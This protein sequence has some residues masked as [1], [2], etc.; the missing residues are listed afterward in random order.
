MRRCRSI[1]PTGLRVESRTGDPVNAWA[2][3]RRLV[4]LLSALAVSVAGCGVAARMTEDAR[5]VLAGV[6]TVEIDDRRHLDG[7]IHYDEVPPLGGAHAPIWVN[8][9]RYVE[10]VPTELAVHTLVH[11]AVWITHPPGVQDEW[12]ERLDRLA[13]SQSHILISPLESATQVV[14]TAWGAQLTLDGP[15]DPALDAF[16]EVYVQGSTTPDPGAPCSGGVGQPV[17]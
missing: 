16:V 8:C 14:A 3:S 4:A 5:G 6:R 2:R 17:T 12:I 11:G 10:E 9:G 15:G 7:V 13:A 1:R